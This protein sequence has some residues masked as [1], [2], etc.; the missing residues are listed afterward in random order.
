M[1]IFPAYWG[2]GSRFW[3]KEHKSKT[4][5]QRAIMWDGILNPFPNRT[6]DW[7]IKCTWLSILRMSMYLLQKND[8]GRVVHIQT[9][10]RGAKSRI[11]IRIA[12]TV[13]VL[14]WAEGIDYNWYKQTNRGYWQ[15]ALDRFNLCFKNG[16]KMSFKK[17]FLEFQIKTLDY[18]KTYQHPTILRWQY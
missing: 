12:L 13:H 2:F 6:Y 10:S 17:V 18:L 5:L 4:M 9:C 1:S 8:R 15:H 14:L 11:P 3:D 7:V 16:A